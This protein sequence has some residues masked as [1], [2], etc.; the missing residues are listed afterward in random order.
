MLN[1][2]SFRTRTCS[3]ISRRS[4]LQLSSAVPLGLGMSQLGEAAIQDRNGTSPRA[5]SVLFVFLWGAP[6][7]LDTCDPKPDAPAEY[8]GPFAVIPT[9]TPGVHFTE[10]L[11]RMAS[12][13]DRYTLLRSHVT[14]AP[15]H[16]DA[17]T[18]ALS[19]FEENPKPVQPNLSL[20]H[21]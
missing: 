1:I 15:G 20:I 3:G 11:P 10:M 2:G 7:H 13:S 12:R 8:R 19:G 5:K 9:R 17:G 21:I 6:S 16:P 18:V 4:F 14:S